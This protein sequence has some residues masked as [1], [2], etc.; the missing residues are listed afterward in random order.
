MT[1][2]V[3]IS[4]EPKMAPGGE[5]NGNTTRESGWHSLFGVSHVTDFAAARLHG[6]FRVFPVA[7]LGVLVTV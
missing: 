6:R 4:Q 2:L 3:I 1:E 7:G 5:K